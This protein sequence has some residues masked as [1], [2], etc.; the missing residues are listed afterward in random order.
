[1]LFEHIGQTHM[2]DQLVQTCVPL[3]PSFPGPFQAS[4]MP[5]ELG[6]FDLSKMAGEGVWVRSISRYISPLFDVTVRFKVPQGNNNGHWFQI[7][8]FMA[9]VK[10]GRPALDE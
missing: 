1:M 7:V 2:S 5:W 8:Q 9:W 4:A 6:Y 3:P 10:A